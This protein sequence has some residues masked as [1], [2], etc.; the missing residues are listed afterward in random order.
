MPEK[1]V[2]QPVR[3]TQAKI[4]GFPIK[5]GYV[6]YAYD[7]GRIYLDKDGTRYLISTKAGSGGGGGGT[8]IIYANGSNTQIIPEDLTERE[9]VRFRMDLAAIE[10]QTIPEI[11]NL[12]LNSDGRF[13]RVLGTDPDDET[14][15]LVKLLAVSGSGSGGSGGGGTAERDINVTWDNTT[16]APGHIFIYGQDNNAV[17]Y[18]ST[19]VENAPCYLTFN[20]I[21][22]DDGSV[23]SFTTN[24]L[25][26]GEAYNFNTSQLPESSNITLQITV[27]SDGSQYNYGMGYQRN[28]TSLRV[29]KMELEK[30]I[31]DAYQPL[32]KSDDLSG[33]LT[34]RYRPIGDSSLSFTLHTYVDNE[35]LGNGSAI[36]ENYLNQ[37]V[38]VSIPRQ[39]HGV[40]SI[41]FKMTTEV[42][43]KTISSNI[44]EYEGAW[45]TSGE[46][47]PIIWVGKYDKKVINYENSYIYYM[48]FDP[49]SYGNGMPAEVHLFKDGLE[50][51]QIDGNYNDDNWLVWDISN[52]YTTTPNQEETTN[53][54]SI[55]CG[56]TRVNVPIVVTTK[57]SRELGLVAPENLILNMS[58]AGR[59]N[60]EIKRNRSKFNST[61]N[62]STINVT[63]QDFNWQNNGW[64]VTDGIDKYGVDSGS[65]LSIANGSTL[66]VE[67]AGNGLIL[68]GAKD[69]TFELRFRVKNVQEY[70]TLVKVIPKFF[71]DIPDEDN[72]GEWISTY[73]VTMNGE[74][75]E[76]SG[77]SLFESEIEE[78]GYRIG[79][80]QYGNLRMDEANSIKTTETEH[81]VV[82]R[83]LN[84]NGYGFCV[85]TQE[86]YFRT[87]SG[88]ANV[89]YCEDEVINLTMVASKS[90]NLCYVY[91]NSILAGA[92]AMPKGTGSG[93][94][95]NS[96][97]V[98]N[99]KYCDFDFYRFRIYELGL[100]MPQVIHNYLS[101][102][103]S[104]ALYD[105]NQITNP[106]DPTALSYDLLVKYN[107]DHPDTP[108]MP[109]AVWQITDGTDEML[110]YKKGNNRAATVEF[111]NPPLDNALANEEITPWYYYTHCP[112]FY[113]EK[114][115]LNVQGTSSQKYP[116][117]NYKLK[118]KSAKDTWVYTQGPLTGCPL[119]KDYY[120]N[121]STGQLVT[122]ESVNEETGEI[123]IVPID[124]A[125]YN[126]ATMVKL[127]KK[128]HMDT[129]DFGTNK[130]TWKID[131]MESSETYNTGFAN[132]MG[133]LVH[134]L[135]TK[136]PLDDLNL[137]I[138]TSDMRTTV[139]GFPVLTFHKY[140]KVGVRPE[141]EY[142]G[143][144]NMNLDKSSNEYYGFEDEHEQPYVPRRTK[145]VLNSTTN[146]YEDVEYQPTI[147][148]IA[149]CWE[150][151]DNQGN[152]C[153]FKYPDA[154]SR[155][156]GFMTLKEGTSGDSAQLELL[157]HYEY[158]YSYY[159]DQLDAAYEYTGFT[160]P[161]TQIAYTNN[162]QIN[163]Y[164][165]DKHKNFEKLF[166][167]L[168]STNPDTATNE[169]LE[170]PV[171]YQVSATSDDPT[172]T[173]T[174]VSS[175]LWSA[176]FTVDTK[177]YRRQKF[178][179]ELPLHLDKEYCLTYYVLT[180]LLLCY[181][182]RGKNCMMAT[183]GPQRAGG[184]YIWYPIFYDID[185]QLGLNNSGAYLW[186]YDA[187]VTK[188]NLF[189]TPTSVLWNN[190]YDLFYDDIVQKY[191]V[192]RG[193][194][195]PAPEDAA[196]NGSLTYENIA[197]AY[198]CNSEVF[199]SYAMAGVRPIVA[200]GLDEYYKYLAPALTAADFAAGKLYAGY[201]DTTGNHKYQQNGPTYVY[202]CQGDKKLTTEL[203][204]R[205]RLNYIDSWWMGGDYR[206]GVVENQIFIRAN[207]NQST[208]SDL[209]LDSASLS[210]LP[211]GAGNKGFSLAEYPKPYFDARPGAFIKP[212]LHQYVSYFAD[213]QPSI[214]VKYD[215]SE[216][217]ED[218][219]WTN[220]DSGKLQSYKTEVDLSQQ[221][222][223]IPGGDYISSLGDIS[224]MYPNSLQIFH[225]QRMLDFKLGSDIPGYKNPLINSSS[226]WELD[227]MPL[228]KSANISKLSN[229]DRELDLT[230]SKKL[231]EFRALG[232]IIERV[233]FAPG[234]PLRIV[235]LPATMTTISLVQN[236]D[237][238][239]II[240]SVP[241]VV[242]ANGNEYVYNDPSTYKGL[243][244]E[245]VTDYTISSANAGHK[246]N[247][248]EIAGGGLGYGSYIILKN[249]YDLKKEATRNNTL[250]IGLTDVEWTPYVAVEKG[251]PYDS[252]ET[253]FFL[254]DHSKYESY[255]YIDEDTWADQLNN[256]L[257]YVWNSEYTH[258]EEHTITNL[259]LFDALIDQ[260]ELAKGRSATS[261]FSNLVE[262]T[263]A[264]IPTITGRLY[265]Y[266]DSEHK[267]KE[268]D[269]TEKYAAYFPYLQITAKE[270]QESNVTKYV[271]VF[272]ETGIVETIESLRSD[273]I[274]PLPPTRNVPSKAGYDFI[275]WSTD[276]A[277]QNMFLPYHIDFNTGTGSYDD[278]ETYLSNFTFSNNNSV[279]TLY[280]QFTIHQNVITI[281]S[282]S[283]KVGAAIVPTGSTFVNPTYI[284]DIVNDL[285]DDTTGHNYL[286]YKDDSTLSFDET[287]KFI[288]YSGN[289]DATWHYDS[290]HTPI[291]DELPPVVIETDIAIYSIFDIVDVHENV[292]RDNRYYNV[293]DVF[294]DNTTYKSLQLL[295]VKE[296]K[297]KITLPRV[298]DGYVIQ[299]FNQIGAVSD[300]TASSVASNI[301]HIF[302]ES[303]SELQFVGSNAC[304]W[305]PE[306]RYFELPNYNTVIIN[307][308]F[309]HARQLFNGIDNTEV[310]NWCRKISKLYQG[311][312]AQIGSDC[313]K[314][315]QFN[316]TQYLQD[317]ILDFSNILFIGTH[318]LQGIVCS[319]FIFGSPTNSNLRY[320]NW[321]RGANGGEILRDT[322]Y[323]GAGRRKNRIQLPLVRYYD[324]SGG[325]SATI[326]QD[327]NANYFYTPDDIETIT[328]FEIIQPS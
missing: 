306:L 26:S 144:Y 81:G 299:C 285:I 101:D 255:T 178:K 99:S 292:L 102:M 215:G 27:T 217:Q 94:T 291:I 131:Y 44:I 198:E 168:D 37:I 126:S 3:G 36:P 190:L 170:N 53:I 321:D 139:Y 238:K 127:A 216:G 42:N 269:L 273:N 173:Y 5:E 229:F 191:R 7:S 208:T 175:G 297:G 12:I 319:G 119:T 248:L 50:V 324:H 58:S 220:V 65:Y 308:A 159:G 83:W 107:K 261:Q 186:D 71:Y 136:H 125:D 105:Q 23:T 128:Y 210:E 2:F 171:T 115:D 314:S 21:N 40:H 311:A 150:L 67:M 230:G 222:V 206:A 218:G 247:N 263:E 260:Y 327:L 296:L 56:G 75:E 258:D 146:E 24:E 59:S 187:D 241:Q 149:E 45:A 133:N 325:N 237:L 4:D 257:V 151:K 154:A 123:E 104:I 290:N 62:T 155:A 25:V 165:Y 88:V 326:E 233:N 277:G 116:R 235:H 82:C 316:N 20:I 174:V 266:N 130:F 134:P 212:F 200:V 301:T 114:V 309:N 109:Y 275:G 43:G 227:T 120:F 140:T 147:A 113:A 181:D 52:L 29:V 203:L 288:G 303:G 289:Q 224:L 66:N 106:L 111:V 30:P 33:A 207:A 284:Y 68:N 78:L 169:T 192:L 148:E 249:L 305:W 98:F 262:T 225:G 236:Q 103:H 76:V 243:Y 246:I 176:E 313:T 46:T 117:R 164:L 251:T 184:E 180:E 295:N 219:V 245:G 87:P 72:P 204:L 110:S 294:L 39:S 234:A 57:G 197:G 304:S 298:V 221:I 256:S 79:L 60:T 265:V 47:T 48:V 194:S 15:I 161:D 32:V 28:I 1:I 259:D 34:L 179:A 122:K 84:S 205:N 310:Q 9:P 14:K 16:I 85:G 274:H 167:W 166:N 268:T 77:P 250:S 13:F 90:D 80:D 64:A 318:A 74:D 35:E 118:Y 55:T 19:T 31:A 283:E 8:G 158:R 328:T 287:Y 223:Y 138:D 142:I 253:Y 93:F 51:S 92:V 320:T 18:P 17:F 322:C 252:T 232:S 22:N 163:T 61:V 96:P 244:L 70:S 73:T 157:N 209:F 267:V 293:I 95:I 54:F 189:S 183:F 69:Y 193:I 91:L 242:T 41:K 145:K 89:R 152:W 323:Q 317:N 213:S 226:D 264:T 286:P 153:S 239:N 63:L 302:W 160:D 199:Q 182:S 315:E 312:L 129:E 135:Y 280:A 143:K 6:Y 228:L 137:G 279:I 231:Q 86:A 177:E 270:V 276:A 10:N 49:V 202:A 254:N 195:N 185:T 132:L 121:T 196:I 100:T 271:R 272:E 282:G 278:V 124:K 172:I 281:Y 156:T 214:P 108:T 300:E 307:N 162:G 201:Y 112:S 141:Y 11:D 240:T 211:S 38:P 188:D 97:F